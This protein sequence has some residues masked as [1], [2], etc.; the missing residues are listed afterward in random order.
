MITK[1]SVYGKDTGKKVKERMQMHKNCPSNNLIL[2]QMKQSNQTIG[3]YPNTT[4][5]SLDE[6]TIS[7][8]GF[9]TKK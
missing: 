7:V 2:R 5:K 4:S 8:S 6:P 9:C 1:A 3:K